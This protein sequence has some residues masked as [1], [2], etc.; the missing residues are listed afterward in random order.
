[1]ANKNLEKIV[2][3]TLILL[4]LS[5]G[6]INY[7]L[8]TNK[9]TQ[10]SIVTNIQASL[11]HSYKN[12][13]ELE[14]IIHVINNGSRGHGFSGGEMEGGFVSKQKAKDVACYLMS[15]RGKP[16][17]EGFSKDAPLFFSSNCAGCHGMDV[18]GIKGSYPNLLRKTFV[19]LER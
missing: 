19:G 16:C 1:M 15:L 6:V 4:A 17:K 5:Y 2:A 10:K 7:F 8:H 9:H 11:S 3:T 13:S 18:K 14:Y 12:M